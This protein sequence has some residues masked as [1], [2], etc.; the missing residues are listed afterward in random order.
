MDQEEIQHLDDE[1]IM[2]DVA[3]AVEE[4]ELVAYYQPVYDLRGGSLVEVE[5]LVRWTLPDGTLIPAALF[6]PSLDRMGVTAGL[7]WFMAEEGSAMQPK[8]GVPVAL[9]FAALHADDPAFIQTLNDTASWHE[10]QGAQLHIELQERF[11]TDESLGMGDFVA[12]LREAGICVTADNVT[13]G[14][15][16][17][18]VLADLGVHQVKLAR[19]AWED[20]DAEQ[21][22]AYVACADE[23]GLLLGATGVESAE[24]T[25]FLSAAG[26]ARAQGFYLGEP[27]AADALLS[28]DVL[29]E[30]H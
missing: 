27:M 11:L 18:P 28:T 13:S 3:R 6:V 22:A 9:N 20:M 2:N 26:C 15:E 5:A 30:N 8:V 1:L 19:S 10:S 16:G 4:R 17:L 29:K 24:D 25:E 23:L 12:S 7:D 14:V 21:L